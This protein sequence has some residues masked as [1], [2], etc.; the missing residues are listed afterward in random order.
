MSCIPTGN[1][2][3]F[4]DQKCVSNDLIDSNMKLLTFIV[5]CMGTFA[6]T[7]TATTMPGMTG[8]LIMN[9]TADIVPTMT[10]TVGRPIS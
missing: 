8:S 1:G 6:A 10:K 2:D 7:M 9:A 5:A 3:W 4:L